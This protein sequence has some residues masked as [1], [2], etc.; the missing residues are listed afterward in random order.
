MST[1]RWTP[2]RMNE[3]GEWVREIGPW[4][5]NLKTAAESPKSSL[6]GGDLFALQSPWPLIFLLACFLFESPVGELHQCS[7]CSMFNSKPSIGLRT[8]KSGSP[9]RR[10]L[11]MLSDAKM[12][13]TRF[14]EPPICT[15]QKKLLFMRN[16]LQL[17]PQSNIINY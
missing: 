9:H 6:S 11:M 17:I 5:G 8:W 14:Y 4:S 2:F 3:R 12:F 1:P 16:E 13:P 7:S 15:K 10:N